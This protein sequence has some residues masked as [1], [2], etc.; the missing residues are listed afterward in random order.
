[1][2]TIVIN[3]QNYDYPQVGD[4]EWGDA[5]TTAMQALATTTL[6]PVKD[7]NDP[8]AVNNFTLYN[9]INFGNTNGLR[10]LFVESNSNNPALSGVFRLCNG[11]LVAWRN[12]DNDGDN[13][14]SFDSDGDLIVNG[15]KVTLHGQIVNADIAAAAG[16]EESKLALDHSTQSLYDNIENHKSDTANPHLTN[17][18]NLVDT[19]IVTPSDND[20]LLYDG[21]DSKWKNIP[22]TVSNVKDV[23]ISSIAD[24]DVLVYD[25]NDSDWK[26][27]D[28][29]SSHVADTNNPH[30]TS[31]SNLNDTTISSA[32]DNDV[33]NYDSISSKWINKSNTVS[34]L[35]DTTISS[36]ASGQVLTYDG[37]DSKWKNLP[38][39][40]ASLT[41]LTD[42]D[43]STSPLPSDGDVLAY[44]SNT[45][46]WINSDSL[47]THISDTNNPHSTTIDNL[48]D[49]T[50]TTVSDKDTLV[51]DGISSKWVNVENSID[52]L[53]NTD[54]DSNT[55]TENDVLVYNDQ[56]FKWENS[57]IMVNHIGN[58]ANPHLTT[59]AKLTDASITTPANNDVLLY[60]YA[61]SQWVN[62]P[63]I[64]INDIANINTATT[65]VTL[66][67]SD[68]R[69]QIF[70]STTG[71][72]VN[73][74][75]TNIKA[76][77]KFIFEFPKTVDY[78]SSPFI[79]SVNSTPWKY[80]HNGFFIYKVT[81]LV[82]N[83][84]S[85]SDYRLDCI[86]SGSLILHNY[87]E[88]D[89]I[90]AP[91][92]GRENY[93]SPVL[94]TMGKG[95]YQVQLTATVYSAN[96]EVGTYDWMVYALTDANDTLI[97]FD[98]SRVGIN[99]ARGMFLFGD[100]GTHTINGVTTT[101]Q[102]QYEPICLTKFAQ[103]NSITN[104]SV[105]GSYVNIYNGSVDIHS[106]F[107]LSARLIAPITTA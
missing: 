37:N 77:E 94:F 78:F 71:F 100:N 41:G 22:N 89:I 84:S 17:L 12:E 38:S 40:S 50:I 31:V 70:T 63:I 97:G 69:H 87:N 57:Q 54:I 96:A 76:G 55:L 107:R 85:G 42:T 33:L 30:S 58:T 59:V 91:V 79:L 81:A 105:R 68:K 64:E 18:V 46:M 103:V 82:D 101:Y 99:F 5:A 4:T 92:Y 36:P 66:T 56:T 21:N 29:V 75:T 32:A 61:N 88:G 16:I 43:I 48:D 34:N 86:P 11:E 2:I 20:T 13:T 73:L 93:T 102:A 60:D 90:N 28:V 39:A 35:S 45:T 47:T 95:I 106:M 49:T 53:S 27:S 67:A 104:V 3:G 51:Y 24:G 44:D 98:S 15:T 19:T 8:T 72:T 65:D 52:N 14:I 26:N 1:M 25:S 6:Q 23:T 80:S 9:D 10:V 62:S 7:L 74:P 83:P